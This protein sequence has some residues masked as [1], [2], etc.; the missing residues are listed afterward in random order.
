MPP[1]TFLTFIFA[2]ATGFLSL[3]WLSRR[4]HHHYSPVTEALISPLLFYNLWVLTWLIRQYLEL[5]LIGSLHPNPARVLFAGAVWVS[6][7]AAILWG[8][9]YLSFTLRA[10]HLAHPENQL[11]NTF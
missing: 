8:A 1:Q 3:A 7:L 4:S 5:T 10:I 9:S 2:L 11:H 6:M